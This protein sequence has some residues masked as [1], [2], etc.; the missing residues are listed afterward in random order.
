MRSSR[1]VLILALLAGAI[2]LVL[3]LVLRTPAR[4]AG[5][6][7][8]V[9]GAAR[10][11]SGETALSATAGPER[12]A[13]GAGLEAAPATRPVGTRLPGDGKLDGRV[14][15]RAS[16]AGVAGARVELLPFPPV[17]A[18]LVER[19]LRLFGL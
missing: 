9:A 2:V 1:G 15:D 19:I 5:T 16:G 11:P 8:A 18:T 4:V 10:D 14:V 13:I 7:D 6:A 17:A 12:D 3:A